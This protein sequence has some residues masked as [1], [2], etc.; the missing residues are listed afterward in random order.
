LDIYEWLLTDEG[1]QFAEFGV[2]GVHWDMVNGVAA[3]TPKWTFDNGV[4]WTNFGFIMNR[5]DPKLI[6]S[7][8]LIYTEDG[9]IMAQQLS[10]YNQGA[11]QPVILPSTPDDLYEKANAAN[12]ARNTAVL[13]III[14]ERPVGDLGK[15]TETWLNAGAQAWFDACKKIA[16]DAGLSAPK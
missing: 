15:I 13:Q 7:A 8:D 1:W 6:P 11:M 16:A 12:R 5:Q 14:G 3:I 4:S 2:K 9:K 10:L